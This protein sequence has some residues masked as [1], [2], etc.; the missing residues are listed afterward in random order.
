MSATRTKTA[1]HVVLIAFWTPL[2]LDRGIDE[3]A[4]KAGWTFE[5]IRLWLMSP[6]DVF[7]YIEQLQPDGFLI[8]GTPPPDKGPAL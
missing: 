7:S 2:E 6:E 3:Y 4:R 8:C 1:R 5:F